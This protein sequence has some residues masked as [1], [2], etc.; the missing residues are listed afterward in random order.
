MA[1][2][3]LLAKI[4]NEKRTDLTRADGEFVGWRRS[5]CARTNLGVYTR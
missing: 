4:L 5:E 2:H 3:R 1:C